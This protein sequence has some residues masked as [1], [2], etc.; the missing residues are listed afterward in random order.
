MQRSL[1]AQVNA[2][3]VAIALMALVAILFAAAPIGYNALFLANSRLATGTAVERGQELSDNTKG[4]RPDGTAAVIEFTTAAGKTVRFDGGSA[5]RYA[6]VGDQV[7]V[8][9]D[10]DDPDHAMVDEAF[11]FVRLTYLPLAVAALGIAVLLAVAWTTLPA[12]IRRT[13]NES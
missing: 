8:R 3:R 10:P 9:Y 4:S 6:A 2:N 12:T 13:G 11:L 5:S 7:Q 1:A